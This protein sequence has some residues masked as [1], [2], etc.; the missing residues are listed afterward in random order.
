M[1]DY[2]TIKEA[3][4]LTGKSKITI[5]RFIKSVYKQANDLGT[6]AGNNQSVTI[7]NIQVIKIE[8]REGKQTYLLHKDFLLKNI[9]NRG[10]AQDHT[11]DTDQKGFEDKQDSNQGYNQGYHQNIIQDANQA[12]TQDYIQTLKEQ[13]KEKDTQ[14]NQLLER[15]RESNLIINNLQ[16]KV[17]LLESPQKKRGF[18]GRLF[19]NKQQNSQ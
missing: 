16:N 4:K 6:N 5:R 11:Q 3:S 12:T 17:L 2:I 1:Q 15:T 7:D 8:P 18:F 19:G 10:F 14:I 13:L 9:D